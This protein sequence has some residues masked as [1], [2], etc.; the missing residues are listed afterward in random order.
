MAIVLAAVV[1]LK[2]V[3]TV[4]TENTAERQVLK[5]EATQAGQFM[6]AAAEHQ[7]VVL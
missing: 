3:I 6:V 2:M 4:L 7:V 1:L 5:M